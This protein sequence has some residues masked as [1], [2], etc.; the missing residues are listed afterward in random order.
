MNPAVA[1]VWA[2]AFAPEF[3][4]R[5]TVTREDHRSQARL[6]IY[7]RD[8]REAAAL[9]RRFGGRVLRLAPDVWWRPQEARDYPLRIGR[10]LLVAATP[11]QRDAAAKRF[12]G[13]V[14]ILIPQGIAFGTGQHATTR[15]C[16]RALAGALAERSG[17]ATVL[18]AGCGSGILGIA[19]A[20]LGAQRVLAFDSDPAAVRVAV[21]NAS[22]NGVDAVLR[23]RKGRLGGGRVSGRYSVV[24]ANI[25]ALPLIANARWLVDRAAPG[26]RLVLSGLRQTQE[27]EV[28]RAFRG[29]RPAARRRSDGWSCLEFD[30]V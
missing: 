29:L 4:S 12:P 3:P 11:A 9:K 30:A 22:A 2:A 7:P 14:V 5:F 16:L 27:A 28:E 17:T 24:V 25:F 20:K 21:E 8:A 23:A 10:R 6:D 26:G 13:R 1:E 18:D 19:A 15:L